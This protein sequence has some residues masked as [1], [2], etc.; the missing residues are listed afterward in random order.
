MSLALGLGGPQSPALWCQAPGEGPIGGKLG[1][2]L[3]PRR[4]AGPICQLCGSEGWAEVRALASQS[5]GPSV[6]AQGAFEGRLGLG[7]LCPFSRPE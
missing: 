2:E 4:P 6:I 3:A 1:L 5:V 7:G